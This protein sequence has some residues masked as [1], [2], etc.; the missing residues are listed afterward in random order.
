MDRD[1]YEEQALIV[2]KLGKPEESKKNMRARLVVKCLCNEFGERIF[3]DADMDA[4]GKLSGKSMDPLFWA[5]IRLSKYSKKDIED[6]EKNS[7]SGQPEL[8]SSPSA[9]E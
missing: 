7:A 5:A 9:S 4:V 1:A 6:L 2:N 3:E 8:P